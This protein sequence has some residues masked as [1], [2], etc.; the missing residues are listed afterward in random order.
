[1][2]A[3]VLILFFGMALTW[4]AVFIG[5]SVKDVEDCADRR[6]V[7]VFPLVFAS[8][9][10]VPIQTMPGWLQAFAKINPFTS[11]VDTVRALMLGGD[12]PLF[13]VENSCWGA[14]IF[15]LFLFLAIRRYRLLTV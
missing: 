6:V 13:A 3:F 4:V 11:L 2:A 10:Y 7:W 14:G 15:I 12:V 5:V 1:M 9:S 8:S